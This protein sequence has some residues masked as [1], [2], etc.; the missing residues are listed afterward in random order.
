M[1]TSINWFFCIFVGGSSRL[2]VSTQD[3]PQEEPAR[4][5][6]EGHGHAESAGR[7]PQNYECPKYRYGRSITGKYK[8]YILKDIIIY[9]ICECQKTCLTKYWNTCIILWEMK[10]CKLLLTAYCLQFFSKSF[11]CGKCVPVYN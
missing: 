7:A 2:V 5:P 3:L 1:K 8:L 11:V 9:M 6:D 4:W 10:S